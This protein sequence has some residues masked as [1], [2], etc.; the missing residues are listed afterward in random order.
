MNLPITITYNDGTQATFVAGLPE[1]SKWERKTGK[2][3]YSMTDV[4]SYQQ[5]DFLF[6]AHSAYVRAAAGKPTKSYEIWE[7]TVQGIDIG[8]SD[9][10]KATQPEA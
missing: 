5:I 9:D 3:V 2:S 1:W 6:L 4:K 7:Q 10:P 8:D